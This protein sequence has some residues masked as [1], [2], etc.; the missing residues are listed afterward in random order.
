MKNSA[1]LV[2]LL[3]FMYD[4]YGV[5]EKY[6]AEYFLEFKNNLLLHDPI[7][8]ISLHMAA[9]SHVYVLEFI[10]GAPYVW[11]GFDSKKWVELMRRVSPRPD[12]SRCIEEIAGYSDIVFL[13]RF[14]RVDALSNFL[15]DELISDMDKSQTRSYFSK[16][17]DL[18]EINDLDKDDLNEVYLMSDEELRRRA[19][20]ILGEGVFKECK[21][22]PSSDFH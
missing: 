14:L 9:Y 19:R 15:G 12:A 4:G 18:V 13:N 2:K 8:V 22:K 6:G 7:E 1:S 3:D 20:V 21:P 11:E 16:F 10:M 17:P 5:P